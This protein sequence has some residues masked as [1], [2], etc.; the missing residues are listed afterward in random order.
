MGLESEAGWFK[1]LQRIWWF[2]PKGWS[3]SM[4]FVCGFVCMSMYQCVK[5]R[6]YAGA[7][8]SIFQVTRL[9]V[10]TLLL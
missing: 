4:T 3:F 1:E 8:V 9:F 6:S 7:K 10:T 2:E 5:A